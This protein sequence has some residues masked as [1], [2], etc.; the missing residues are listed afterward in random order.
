MVHSRRGDVEGHAL[1]HAAVVTVIVLGFCRAAEAQVLI[2]SYPTTRPTDADK[3]LAPFR[4]ELANAGVFVKPDDVITV[5]GAVLPLP[6]VSDPSLG[7]SYPAYLNGQVELGASQ[8]FKQEYAAGIRTLEGVIT[9]AWANAALVVRDP[10]AQKWLSKAYASLAFAHRRLATKAADDERAAVQRRDS[11]AVEDARARRER[12]ERAAQAAVREQIRSYTEF[13]IGRMVGPEIETYAE[14]ERKALD[15][16]PRGTL[17]VRVSAFDAQVYIDELGRGRGNVRLEG[18]PG[19]HRVLVQRQGIARRYTAR[20]RANETTTLDI[21]WSA[22]SAFQ[23]TSKFIGFEWRGNEDRTATAAGRYARTSD[24]H[25]I[26]IASVIERGQR[27]FL[28]AFVII[29]QRGT[30]QRHRAIEIVEGDERCARDLARFL[31]QGTTSDC[32]IDIPDEAEEVPATTTSR[33]PWWAKVVFG[34]GAVA[35]GA[36]TVVYLVAP[37][38]DHTQPT[39]DDYKGPAVYAFLGSAGVAAAGGYLWL[40]ASHSDAT[41][42]T[43]SVGTAAIVSG[44]MLVATDED[45][46]AADRGYWQRERYRDSASMGVIVGGAGIALTG[47]GL[48]LWRREPRDERT[49]TDVARVRSSDES[50][51]LLPIFNVQGSRVLFGIGGEF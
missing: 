18:W 17:G 20:V 34:T 6:G 21:D 50:S 43:L 15:S 27:R 45:A 4:D 23:A 48:W 30:E 2:E 24:R 13:P 9:A 35:V 36:S 33:A 51:A 39:Y 11:K 12:E 40:R 44:V 1:R 26:Y 37:D 10:D 14:Q 19:A 16:L 22:D 5:A 3:L 38:D 7:A 29:K 8:V 49:L 32:L 31:V 28:D 42:A 46:R 25:D 41:A 47:V